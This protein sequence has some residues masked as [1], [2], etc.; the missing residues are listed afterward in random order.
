MEVAR[1]GLK[2]SVIGESAVLSTTSVLPEAE[3]VVPVDFVAELQAAIPMA[4][5]LAT[6][7]LFKAAC[8]IALNSVVPGRLV[9]GLLLR[10]V[11]GP[12]VSGAVCGS[13]GRCPLRL[14][15]VKGSAVEDSAVEDS[16]VEDSA[17]NGS[18]GVPAG[19]PA[20]GVACS[21]SRSWAASQ[22]ALR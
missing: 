17:V 4:R 2:V 8:L 19:G 16:A 1:N 21:A 5:T 3:E 14:A 11:S 6:A 10:T 7:R 9:A 22:Q 18:A 12:C 13:A 20:I 15:A